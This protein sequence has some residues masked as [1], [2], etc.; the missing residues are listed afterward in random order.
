MLR[1]SQAPGGGTWAHSA[2]YPSNKGSGILANQ[3]YIGRYIWNKNDWGNHP[4][5]GRRTPKTR[6]KEDWIVHEHPELRI[7]DE[8]L[9]AACQARAV[10][11]KRDTAM[12]YVDGK[13]SGGRGPK[14]LFSGLLKCGQCNGSF[15]IQGRR[16]YGCATYKNRGKSVCSNSL[17][18]K[19]SAIEEIL[20]S[21]IK[22]TLLSEEAFL[23]FEAE[24]RLLLDKEKPDVR[25]QNRKL[26]DAKKELDNIMSAIKAGIVTVSTKMALQEAEHKLADAQ[27]KIKSF[28]QFEP[29][30]VLPKAKARGI[31]NEMIAKLEDVPAAREV[32]RALIG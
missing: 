30:K 13:G 14:F 19:R 25:L 28:E 32:L 12:R 18:V 16:D 9:W 7:I 31:Y 1:A 6:P 2:I 24:V 22:E 26:T 3:L 5:T 17:K 8:S 23:A 21:G 27:E 10:R 29:D 15:V 4:K 20:L 11:S